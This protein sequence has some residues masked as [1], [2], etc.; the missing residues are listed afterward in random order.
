M[1]LPRNGANERASRLRMQSVEADHEA[2]TGAS[3]VRT[4]APGARL[5][6]YDVAHPEQRFETA[7]ILSLTHEACDTT[8]ETGDGQPSY[9]NSFTALPARLAATPHRA[10][11]RPRIR[12]LP[13]SGGR[14][15][16]GDREPAHPSGWSAPAALGARDGGLG[17]AG[18]VF[19]FRVARARTSRGTSLEARAAPKP[20]GPGSAG[21][22]AAS[23]SPASPGM[24]P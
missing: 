21:S 16:Q 2:L 5:T 9:R 11:E 15:G 19:P 17:K 23:R 6:L 10:T 1:K 18:A 20:A 8:Y 22:I 12:R 3:T 24:S 4:L 7:A 14:V 13:R